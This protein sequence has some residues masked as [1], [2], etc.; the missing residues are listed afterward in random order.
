MHCVGGTESRGYKVVRIYGVH[1]HYNPHA[2]IKLPEPMNL[3]QL[4]ALCE[5]V[6]H[7]LHL[8]QAAQTLHRSQPTLSRQIQQLENE[9]GVKLFE[10][11]RNRLISLTSQGKEI[12]EI[13]R[14]MVSDARDID[15]VAQEQV[16]GGHGELAVATTHTQARYT[17]PAVIHRFMEKHPGV[18]LSLLQGTPAQCCD[19]VAHGQADIAICTE[20]GPREDIVPISCYLLR[21]IVI[22][23]PRHPLVRAR[24]L[25]LE[26]IAQ[27]PIITYA[28]GFS[29][30]AIVNKTFHNAGLTPKVLL[31]A[32]DADISKA[33]VEMGLG[34]AILASVAFDPKRDKPLRRLPAD[35]LFEASR[36]NVVLRPN[37]YLRG[38]ALS[39]IQMFA[40][41][42]SLSEIRHMVANPAATRLRKRDLPVL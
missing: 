10:R 2:P 1:M 3:L 11:N 14:R 21:R 19:M 32:I 4:K 34:I 37:A 42:I 8:S 31:S 12:F 5:I 22:T 38:F 33:Y 18:A 7:G 13:A 25:T 41:D 15:R 17:L 16:A 29:G 40:P 30:R 35:H 23:P 28:E 9:L 36:L 26:A 24:P 27:Y 39:F 6:E 20:T